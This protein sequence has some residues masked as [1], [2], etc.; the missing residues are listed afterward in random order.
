MSNY[1]ILFEFEQPWFISDLTTNKAST[2]SDL[3]LWFQVECESGCKSIEI[4]GI[5]DLDLIS[6]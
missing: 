4:E 5:D 1:Q 6:N 2:E 3:K